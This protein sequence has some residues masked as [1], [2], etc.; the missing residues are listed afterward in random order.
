MKKLKDKVELKPC[1]KKF[2]K[3]EIKIKE[4]YINVENLSEKEIIP[5]LYEEEEE[6]IKSLERSLES[7]IDKLFDKNSFKDKLYNKNKNNII[8][9]YNI[10]MNIL[11]QLQEILIEEVNEENVENEKSEDVNENAVSVKVV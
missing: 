1:I 4:N 8:D 5:D 9:Y 11:N 3:N 6:D 7:S 2:N 10:G